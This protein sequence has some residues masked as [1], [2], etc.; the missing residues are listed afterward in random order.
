MKRYFTL[1]VTVVTVVF[2]LGVAAFFLHRLNTARERNLANA[3]AAFTGITSSVQSVFSREASNAETLASE[4]R[5]RVWRGSEPSVI[6]VTS[7]ANGLEYL[8]ARSPEYL[9]FVPGSDET[10]SPGL[11]YNTFSET[12][13][14]FRSSY[15][16]YPYTLDAVFPVLSNQDLFYILRDSL[17]A[18]LFFS[19]GM[20]MLVITV[21]LQKKS[22]P[23]SDT[24]SDS[25]H[26]VFTAQDREDTDASFDKTRL[27][28]DEE[29]ATEPSLPSDRGCTVFSSR[30]GMTREAHLT[31]R[32]DLEIQRA[33]YNEEDLTVMIVEP[34]MP[35]DYD[36]LSGMVLELFP[37]EDLSFEHGD[38]GFCVLLPDTQIE[39]GI[40]KARTLLEKVSSEGMTSPFVGLSSRNARITDATRMM[41]EASAA[42]ER[43]HQ[44]P[45]HIVGFKPDP[46]KYRDYLS[47]KV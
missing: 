23:A 15:E 22:I 46:Q 21:L 28:T 20:L 6:I 37:F 42:L 40:R 12:V 18:V 11:R 44:D 16:A 7:S 13:L 5:S 39:E 33:S 14:S 27:E 35:A 32:L 1:G 29:T 25:E 26:I 19:L 24:E 45:D 3:N 43:A 17:V 38:A 4:I 41:T 8:W 47:N 30:T 36:R 34:G 10:R 9:E 2:F 31:T